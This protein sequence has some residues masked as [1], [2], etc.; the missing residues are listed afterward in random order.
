M[1]KPK[2]ILVIRLSAMGDVAMA[3]PALT[4][5]QKEYPEVRLTVLTRKFFAP[6]FSSLPNVEV[7]EADL[8][9]AHKGIGGLKRLA[10]TLRARKIDAV[11][12][13]HNVLRSNIL[14]RFF[15]FYRIP[16][17][18]IDKARAEKKALTRERNKRFQKLKS[19]QQRYADVF[20]AL[21]YPIDLSEF[22]GLDKI[23]VSSNLF[24]VVGKQPY[25]WVGVAP[26][27]QHASK[28]YPPKLMEKVLEQ[29]NSLDNVRVFL[30][31]GPDEKSVLQSWED[32]FSHVTSMV[33]K[34]N[35][36]QELALI[37][38]LDAMLSMDS[39]NGH[40][41]ANFKVPVITLWGLTHP[42]TGFA[43][44]KQ[45]Q[46]LQLLPDLEK[47]PL[48]PTSVYGN[49]VP[50]GYEDAMKTIAPITV[51]KKIKEVL[52]SEKK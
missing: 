26:F 32:R 50:S 34:L 16:V 8:H 44:Y 28:I 51:V 22:Q 11:A 43:P 3:V 36:E 5:M 14:K 29:L 39:G 2:H 47:Y 33:G 49:K 7:F 1:K 37:S 10:D 41:A 19:T 4:C 17:K 24:R 9:G 52:S 27:A 38:N 12:D 13:L 48:I 18:Q 40:L 30:F 31:G 20:E 46:A 23:K 15:R 6:I 25:K 42:Y 35:L 45:P 21:G